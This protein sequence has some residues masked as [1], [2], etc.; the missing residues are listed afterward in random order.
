MPAI[1]NDSPRKVA[2]QAMIRSVYVDEREVLVKQVK[3]K[4][5][6]KAKG[7]HFFF[8][9]PIIAAKGQYER[10]GYKP[11]GVDHKGD[12]LFM[13]PESA[14]IQ[15]L[16]NAAGASADAKNVEAIASDNKYKTRTN[17]GRIVS[18]TLEQE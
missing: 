5:G 2:P 10:E 13:R 6:E 17:D 4:L 3:T 18:P 16:S 7:M 12:P 14:H 8:G 15:H 1:T 11:C 9:D